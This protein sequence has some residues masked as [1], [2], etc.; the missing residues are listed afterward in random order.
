MQERRVT[1]VTGAASGIG[2]EVV[3]RF[4]SDSKYDPIYAVDIN[5]SIH[6]VFKAAQYP[7]VIALQVDIRKGQEIVPLCLQRF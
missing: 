2:R 3:K 6:T 7:Q 5:P 1:I 4:A